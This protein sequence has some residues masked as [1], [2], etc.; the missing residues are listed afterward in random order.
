MKE[1]IAAIKEHELYQK[2]AGKPGLNTFYAIR[3]GEH[4]YLDYRNPW[5]NYKYSSTRC[6][7]LNVRYSATSINLNINTFIYDS[8]APAPG[9]KGLLTMQGTLNCLKLVKGYHHIYGIR[10]KKPNYE[11]VEFTLIESNRI[12]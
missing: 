11:I 6:N 10:I 4:G 7:Y 1:I 2:L 5:A 8:I 3:A 12:I 9:I